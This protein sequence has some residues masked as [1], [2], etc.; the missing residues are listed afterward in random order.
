MK[1]VAQ[2]LASVER[3]TINR[4]A[5]PAKAPIA[6]VVQALNRSFQ[7]AVGYFAPIEA[8]F[9]RTDIGSGPARRVGRPSVVSK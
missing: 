4:D 3:G 1:A 6:G 2:A 9:M 7:L 5:A 8:R